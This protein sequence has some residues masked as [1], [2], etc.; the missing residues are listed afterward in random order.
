PTFKG[1]EKE[2]LLY[3]GVLYLGL[4]ITQEGPKV[5]EYNVRL[6]D[7][8]TQVLLPVLKNDMGNLAEAITTGGLNQF[9]FIPP[10]KAC[11]GV[12]VAAP[13][14][15]GEYKK[16]LPVDLKQGQGNGSVLIFHASTYRD[17]SGNLKT[18][19]GRCFTVV[20]MGNNIFEAASKAYAQISNV[21][22]EGAWYRK[23]IGIL[24]PDVPECRK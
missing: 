15:P 19:G 22:F 8:E 17:S 4:I 14:Y 16:H 2:G 5:L 1:L 6:G 21:C 12:V 24:L 20:G 7:P 11:V 18:Q 9:P 23:D 10:D 3:Q 13:G